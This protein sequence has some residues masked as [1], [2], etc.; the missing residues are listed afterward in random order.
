MS[1]IGKIPVAIPNGVKAAVANG[2]V[3]IEGPKGKL[4]YRPA[5]G[6]NVVQENNQFV[7]SVEKGASGNT[8]ADFGTTRAQLNNMVQGVS[9][10]WKR[11]LELV[12]VGFNAEAQGQKLTLSV[13]FSHKVVLEVPKEVKVAVRVTAAKQ[14]MIDLESANRE[15]VGTMAQKIRRVQPPEPYLGKGIRYVEETVRRKAGKTGKK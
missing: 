2:I 4:E 11:S 6:I 7:V 12:G 8:K 14:V 10:G 3:S 1:R 5:R 9:A 13:G 15:M